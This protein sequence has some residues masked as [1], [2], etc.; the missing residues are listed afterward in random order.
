MPIS[1]AQHK[2]S[3]KARADI[4]HYID[5]YNAERGHSSL[6]GKTPEEVWLSGLPSLKEAA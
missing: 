1:F 4:A 2:V 3:T 5:W 6:A